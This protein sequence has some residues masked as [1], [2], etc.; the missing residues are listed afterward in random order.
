MQSGPGSLDPARP[1]DRVT[2]VR[3]DIS[4]DIPHPTRAIFELAAKSDFPVLFFL[5]IL[6]PAAKAISYSS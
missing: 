4:A 2:P 5:P 1:D 6:E 3:E